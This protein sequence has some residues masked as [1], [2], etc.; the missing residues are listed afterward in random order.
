[1][2]KKL[3][4][5][6]LLQLKGKALAEV[7]AMERQLQSTEGTAEELIEHAQKLTL[8]ENAMTVLQAYIG[9]AYAP[10][11]APRPAPVAAAPA[12]APPSEPRVITPEISS[13]YAAS[14]GETE[15]LAQKRRHP[16][17]ENQEGE[18]E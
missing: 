3:Y 14:V 13:T 1:M 2:S 4:E 16:E 7:A 10:P 5:A 11:A 12:P 15:A 6:T 18:E 8:Y 9:P 17:A